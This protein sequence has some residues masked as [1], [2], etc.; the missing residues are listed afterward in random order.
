MKWHPM[1]LKPGGNIGNLELPPA[2]PKRGSFQ[3][4]IPIFALIATS[5]VI[6]FKEHGPSALQ[7][8]AAVKINDS[9]HDSNLQ[10]AWTPKLS[11]HLAKRCLAGWRRSNVLPNVE[12]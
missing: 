11:I 10:I 9:R 1:M 2:K 7:P 8:Q 5:K 6:P 12:L 4:P 3:I